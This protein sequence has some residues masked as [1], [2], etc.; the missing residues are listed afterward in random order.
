MN[1]G[2]GRRPSFTKRDMAAVEIDRGRTAALARG[3][4]SGMAQT[5]ISGQVL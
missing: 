1:D 3:K 5:W 2:S 4:E